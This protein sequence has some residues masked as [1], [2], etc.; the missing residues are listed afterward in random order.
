MSALLTV[1]GEEI[2]GNTDQTAARLDEN[3]ILKHSSSNHPVVEYRDPFEPPSKNGMNNA[4]REFWKYLERFNR[5]PENAS[6]EALA[7]YNTKGIAPSFQYLT[8]SLDSVLGNIELLKQ[9]RKI[10]GERYPWVNTLIK[11]YDLEVPISEE[12]F[13]GTAKQI[14]KNYETLMTKFI[15]FKL[16]DLKEREFVANLL[17]GLLVVDFVYAKGNENDRDS[18]DDIWRGV[19]KFNLGNPFSVALSDKL[20]I[21]ATKQ[22]G[23]ATIATTPKKM[24]GL[25]T[26]M[27]SGGFHSHAPVERIQLSKWI[28]LT[29]GI[30]GKASSPEK[31]L[32]WGLMHN[33]HMQAGLKEYSIYV[34]HCIEGVRPAEKPWGQVISNIFR[35]TY[36]K[37][38]KKEYTQYKQ[39][40]DAAYPPTP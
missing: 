19:F 11:E 34:A 7:I 2:K 5:L 6:E 40:L 29:D 1:R 39:L 26:A 17:E 14:G 10:F 3:G 8:P 30:P 36:G 13:S 37:E 22:I 9:H 16:G 12:R 35:I 25:T 23:W 32:D 38:S 28:L 31:N 18:A 21:P 24:W 27:L 20:I 33:C 4:Q 15:G